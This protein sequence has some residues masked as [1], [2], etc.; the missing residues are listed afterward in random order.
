M[1]LISESMIAT[2]AQRELYKQKYSKVEMLR[3][4]EVIGEGFIRLVKNDIR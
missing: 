3:E 1:A 2:S 4:K